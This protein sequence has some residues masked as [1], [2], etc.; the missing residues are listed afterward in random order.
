MDASRAAVR[1]AVIVRVLPA[2]W[3]TFGSTG[4]RLHRF[5]LPRVTSTVPS[6]SSTTG[7][8]EPPDVSASPCPSPSPAV[9]QVAFVRFDPRL[10]CS[11]PPCAPP[12]VS[13]AAVPPPCPVRPGHELRVRACVSAAP[14]PCA[15]QPRAR[16]DRPVAWPSRF[17]RRQS[18]LPPWFF[19]RG[20]PP[21]LWP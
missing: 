11:A 6:S 10:L 18:V 16:P 1:R 20:K 21:P 4:R 7:V 8:V 9:H 15:W 3:S 13:V 12:C 17:L 2:A 19:R 5:R 14:S